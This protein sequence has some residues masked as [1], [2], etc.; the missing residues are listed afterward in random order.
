MGFIGTVEDGT[1]K[2]PPGV[3]LPNGTEVRVEPQSLPAQ[4][5]LPRPFIT[6]TRDFGFKPGIDLTKLAQLADVL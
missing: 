6:R 2:L 1:I 3:D 4:I 5:G